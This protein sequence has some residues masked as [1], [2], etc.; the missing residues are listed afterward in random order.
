MTNTVG[1]FG[2]I[3]ATCLQAEMSEDEGHSDLESDE[4]LD[5]AGDLVSA[6]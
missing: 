3:G 6:T 4:D 2:L 1:A 5:D